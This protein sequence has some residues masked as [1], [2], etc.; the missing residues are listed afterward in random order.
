MRNE[1]KLKSRLLYTSTHL[2]KF[3]KE[4]LQTQNLSFSL[5][6]MWISFILIH[7]NL[8]HHFEVDLW[9]SMVCVYVTHT[10]NTHE[11]IHCDTQTCKG[12]CIFYYSPSKKDAAIN[13]LV[14]T[15]LYI[16][17]STSLE[18]VPRNGNV[19]EILEFQ[20]LIQITKQH[21]QVVFKFAVSNL[22]LYMD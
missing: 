18:L 19:Q 10:Y 8:F 22:S 6:M 14:Q 13:I 1:K 20:F 3:I 9:H 5:N 11:I 21:S 12:F 7:I 2:R 15:F 4:Y 16:C 17:L